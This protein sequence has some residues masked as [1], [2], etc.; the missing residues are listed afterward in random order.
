[1]ARIELTLASLK[2]LDF[3]KVQAEWQNLLEFAVRDCWERPHDDK[4]RKVLLQFEVEPISD[5]HD[6]TGVNSR[7]KLKASVPDRQSRDYQL[8]ITKQGHLY[9]Q[10]DSPDNPDQLTLLP[11][12]ESE[13]ASND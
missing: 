2:E 1:M 4:T 3:G 7:F 8:G 6:C 12:D 13:D 10:E 5:G 9:F 11:K